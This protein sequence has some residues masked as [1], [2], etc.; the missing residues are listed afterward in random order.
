MRKKPAFYTSAIGMGDLISATPVIK[1]LSEIYGESVRVFSLEPQI[2]SGLPYVSSSDH[3]SEWREDPMKEKWLRKNYDLHYTYFKMGKKVQLSDERGIEMR[4]PQIDSRQYHAIDLG[5][6]LTPDE[7][8][9]DFVPLEELSLDL[10]NDYVCFHASKTWN[11]RSWKKEEWADLCS[12]IIKKGISVVL[13]GKDGLSKD[14]IE[15]LRKTS[16]GILEKRLEEELSNKSLERIE[17][18]GIIDL[19]N[20][21]NLSQLWH[22]LD[23]ARCIVTM[24]SGVLHMAGTTNSYIIQLGSSIS[25]SFRAPYRYGSQKYKYYYLG[26]SCNLFC[27]SD[28]RYSLRDWERGYNGGTPIQSISLVDGCLENKNSFECHPKSNQV[29]E[30]ILEILSME[31]DINSKEIERKNFFQTKK[32]TVE[33]PQYS[34]I[35]EDEYPV[36]FRVDYKDFAPKLEILGDSRDPRKFDVL[37]IDE[38]SKEIL[39]K[40]SIQTNHWVRPNPNQ[41]IRWM[42]TVSHDGETLFESIG[43]ERII[44]SSGLVHSSAKLNVLVS[45]VSNSLGDTI[46][47]MPAVLSYQERESCRVYVKCKWANILKNSY[48]TLIFIDEAYEDDFDKVLNINYHFEYPLQEGFARDLGFTQWVYKRPL[49]DFV[50]KERPIKNKYVAI[51]IQSTSQ[52]KYWNYPDGWNILCKMLRKEGLTPVCIDQYESFGIKGNYN[53]VPSSS[54]KRLDNSIEDSMNYIYHAEFFIGVSSG[55][56]WIAHSMGKKV[57]MISGVTQPWNEFQEDCL[58]IINK[59]SCHGCFHLTDKYNFDPS[60]WMWCPEHGGTSRQFECTKTIT[61]EEVFSKIKSWI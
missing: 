38:K 39:Q 17:Q 13:V 31:K 30:K 10:P 11:S 26:G 23:R 34:P 22:V 61:P 21:T 24:D 33:I 14:E 12:R 53:L 48:P 29:E 28:M 3:I 7:M 6:N 50:P 4:H 52:C 1:K 46:G 8:Q 16:G 45:F 15:K 27:G 58:R 9:C 20:K 2:F 35:Y 49:V 59:D 25:P 40:S 32:D 18:S 36:K 41:G 19:T 54:V 37:F 43:P 47:G 42:V 51:G 55:L 60:S 44:N 5:F 56:S 57:V